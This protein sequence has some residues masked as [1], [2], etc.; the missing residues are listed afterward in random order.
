ME[1]PAMGV[2]GCAAGAVATAQRHRAHPRRCAAGAATDFRRRMATDPER[3]AAR[4]SGGVRAACRRGPAARWHHR[5]R[6]GHRRRALAVDR[7]HRRPAASDAARAAAP[8]VDSVVHPLVRH[9]RAGQG[10]PRRA[11]SR[12]PAVPQYLLRDPAGRPQTAGNRRH[13]WLFARCSDCASSCC[14]ARPRR[15]WSGFGSRWRSP[16]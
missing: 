2:A 8:G 12:L 5:G 15:C 6:P 9:R 3:E 10:Q 1:H 16:G 13:S 4:S 14:P 11:R 7:G